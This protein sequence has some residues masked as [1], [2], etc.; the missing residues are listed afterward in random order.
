MFRAVIGSHKIYCYITLHLGRDFFSLLST[1]A[2]ALWC[3]RLANLVSSHAWLVGIWIVH[4]FWLVYKCVF[5]ASWSTKMM[6]AIWLAVSKLWE[7]SF[8]KEIKLY[9]LPL[10]II[11]LF[12]K[13]ENNNFIEEIKLCSPWLHS[14]VKRKE[15]MFYFLIITL[16]F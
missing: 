11:F 10:Y 14:L 15:K 16:W 3:C 9:I 7:L 5:I 13:S 2:S 1:C 4:A 8:K 12:V 6:W